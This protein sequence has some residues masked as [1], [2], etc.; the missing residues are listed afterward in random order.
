[1]RVMMKKY[2]HPPRIAGWFIR[3]MFPDRGE[4]SIL[5][6]M[7]ETYR[8]LAD[9]KGLFWARI[10]FWG[11]CV[12]AFPYFLVDES[13]W[14]IHMFNNYLKIALRNILN[15]KGY[16]FINILGLALG[17]ACGILI[18]LFVHFELSYDQF[19][20]KK[21]RIHRV[22]VKVM[23]GDT[24][25]AQTHTPA[26]L[27][28]TFYQDYP[29]VEISLRLQPF[30]GGVEVR[31]D[32][33]I[34]NEYRVVASDPEFF[35][36]FSFPL[37]SGEAERVLKEP[38]SVVISLSTARKYFGN[39]DPLDHVLTIGKNEFQVTGVMVDMPANSHFHFDLIVSIVTFDGIDNTNWAA[40]NYRT[41]LQL[42]EGVFWKEFEAKFPDLVN[43]YIFGGNYNSWTQKGNFWEFYLQPLTSI[44]LH[45][46]LR[47]ELELNGSAAY[48]FLFFIIAIFILLLAA[49]NYMNLSTARSAG[50]G[51][52]VGVRK[53]VGATRGILMRQFLSESILSSLFALILAMFLVHLLLPSFGNIVQRQLTLPYRSVPW[54]V[55]GLLGLA[56][57]IGILSGAYPSFFLSSFRPVTVLQGR[58]RSASR[59]T[60][61]RHTLVL[62]QFAISI[63]LLIGTVIVQQQLTF[64][65][66]KDLGFNKEQVVVVKTPAPL[67]ERSTPFKEALRQNP[68]IL[69][70]S[71]SNTLPGK[72]FNNCLVQ[73]EGFDQSVTMNI[74]VCEP[75]FQDVIQ[76]KMVQGRFFSREFG[77]DSTA[78][79]LNQTAADLLAWDNP[80]GKTITPGSGITFHVIGVVQDYHFE[81]LHQTVRPAAMALL[82]GAWNWWPE[83]YISLR[84]QTQ[85][86]SGTLGYLKSTWD[87]FNPGKPLEYTFLDNDYA[88]LYDNEQRTR[89]LFSVFSALAIFIACLGLFGLASFAAEQRTKEVGIRKVLG[90]SVARIFVLHSQEFAKWVIL[91]NIIAWPVAYYFMNNW[92]QNFAYRIDLSVWIFI[93]C[94][95]ATLV[96]ALLAVSCQAIKAAIANPIDSLRY[97]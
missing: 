61:L 36:M 2:R 48:V 16:S 50:R 69:E 15:H 4:C 84:V 37:M 47:G 12:K 81:S 96:I 95:L 7:I 42:R 21:E 53:V 52:E 56:V 92:L 17:L 1:M 60:R 5:G 39:M 41:Y 64:F 90:A 75:E 3:R 11:Q 65:M 76:F 79:I 94:G 86:L 9:D 30:D 73:P 33:K 57:G 40:C 6:D 27:T 29:D 89:R 63:A 55:P 78:V 77:T 43:R 38:N 66:N 87:R 45:S 71:G 22:S 82:N 8:Y 46:D 14:R 91:A 62:F 74:S 97:E 10:W 23:F 68:A 51:R 20:E 44:H 34:F 26:I 72:F 49:V 31:R 70:V 24:H 59:N 32:E 58:V 67:G 25:A 88:A 85:N 35:Q 83:Q 93:I 80:L 19:H 13:T 18:L 54:L 28:P